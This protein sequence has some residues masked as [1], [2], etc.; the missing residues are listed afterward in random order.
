MAI[1]YEYFKKKLEGEKKLVEKE[2][3]GVGRRNPDNPADWEA[4][5]PEGAVQEADETDAADNIEDFNE[6]AAILSTLETRYNEIKAALERIANGTYGTCVVG[7][8]EIELDRLEA[9]PSATT[10]K[11][12]MG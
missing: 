11:A 9:N 1:D 3:E 2:L 5:P 10:C 4:T 6:N 12:H 8:E 7:G